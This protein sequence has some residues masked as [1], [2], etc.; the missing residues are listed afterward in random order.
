MKTI[1]L[2]TED[3][4]IEFRHIKKLFS[5][6]QLKHKILVNQYDNEISDGC[7][8]A[9]GGTSKNIHTRISKENRM[10]I[11]GE[12]TS[13]RSYDKSYL[14]QFGTVI[15]AHKTVHQKHRQP[16]GHGWFFENDFAE[17]ESFKPIHKNHELSLISSNKI[18][19]R[20]HRQRLDFCQQLAE[21][22]GCQNHFFGRGINEFSSKWTPLKNY[23]YTI[24]IE[25][26]REDHWITE[27]LTDP[28]LAYTFP[29][30][31]GAQNAIDYYPENSFTAIDINDY[32]ASKAAIETVLNNDKHYLE[33][34]KYLAEARHIYL[35]QHVFT[36]HIDRFVTRN[37][38]K[39][40]KL[41]PDI[42][43]PDP[44]DKIISQMLKV[45]QRVFNI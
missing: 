6:D 38:T 42:I 19:T 27:K 9:F 16:P 26:S 20:G 8:V 1:Y 35:Y 43:R 39:S 7:I 17:L 44:G 32:A 25:N 22:F 41:K 10:I 21:D 34:Q 15:G 37:E 29:F 18:F 31:Y 23:K 40:T 11:L 2:F 3:P 45:A 14:N 24:A 13:I 36:N 4:A 12:C 30:Y 28:Y 5:Q 33:H